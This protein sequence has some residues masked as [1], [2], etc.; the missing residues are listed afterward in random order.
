MNYVRCSLCGA[1]IHQEELE[2]HDGFCEICW[3]LFQSLKEGKYE[4]LPKLNRIA[5]VRTDASGIESC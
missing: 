5:G 1:T 3:L 2:K 4:N